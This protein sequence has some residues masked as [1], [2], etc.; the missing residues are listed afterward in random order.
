MGVSLDRQYRRRNLLLKIVIYLPLVFSLLFFVLCY[1]LTEKPRP[2]LRF[3]L[4]IY[5]FIFCLISYFSYWVSRVFRQRDKMELDLIESEER[6]RAVA[7]TALDA[8]ISADR[9]GN[10]IFWNRGA[11]NIFGYDEKEVLGKSLTVLMPAR[12]QEAHKKGIQRF[13]VTGKSELLGKT[14]ELGGL[15]KDGSEFPL[16]LSVSPWKVEKGIFFTGILRDISERKKNERIIQESEERLRVMLGGIQDYAIFMLDPVGTIMT[17]NE[18]A[19]RIKGYK[20]EEIIGSHFSKFYTSEDIRADKPVSMLEIASEQGKCEDEGW[21]VRK[22]G[23]RFWAN[24]VVTALRDEHGQLKGFC[25]VE[26]DMTERKKTQEV[27][28]R[29]SIELARIDAERQ[30][31]ELFSYTASHDLREP[32]QKI[33]GFGGLL[34]EHV[35]KKPDLKITDYVERMQNAAFRMNQLIEDLLHFSKITKKEELF[36]AVDLRELIKEVLQDLEIRIQQTKGEV[37]VDPLPVVKAD[38]LQMRQLFQNLIAN[39]LKFHK[40]EIPPR[41]VVKS[42]PMNHL[43]LEITVEDN[44][45]GF[46]EKYLDKIFKP[47]ERLHSRAEYEGSGLGLAICQKIVLNHDGRI[48]AK[49]SPGNGTV[50][51]V[52]LPVFHPQ[53]GEISDG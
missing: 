41:V 8:V 33:I 43:F 32:L 4:L 51:T 45:I 47:F 40:K 9:H 22:D 18:S 21:R 39:A 3:V 13:Y 50:F 44:G 29:K 5:G 6:F 37:R 23:S 7:E 52:T 24:V 19:E 48:T 16:E 34:R 53:K 26:R 30:Q 15:K 20:T 31:L 10:I 27:L 46:D 49:S 2:I 12:Y 35:E 28:M 36:E 17:W 38:R 42:K 1:Y 14:V 11:K 25:K